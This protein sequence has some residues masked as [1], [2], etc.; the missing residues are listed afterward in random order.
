MQYPDFSIMQHKEFHDG[1]W[2]NEMS[3]WKSE[4]ANIP[5]PLPVLP[6]AKKI[7]RAPLGIYRSNTVKIELDS[8]LASRIGSTCRRTKVSP[9]NFYLATFRVL[10]YRR[11]GGKLADICIGMADS[12]RNNHLVTDSVG[13][14]LNSLPLRFQQQPSEVFRDALNETRSKVITTL[15]N[16]KVPFDVLLNEVNAPRTS[17][18]SLLFQAFVNYREGFRREDSSVDAIVKPFSSTLVRLPMTWASI[19]SVIQKMS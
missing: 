1:Q 9:F 5:E 15:A 8:S 3:H 19:F 18:S 6:P 2:E 17:T 10:L 16:S 12:G 7:S 11:A 14:F 4:F 13:F